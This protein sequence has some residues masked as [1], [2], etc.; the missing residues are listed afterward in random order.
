MRLGTTTQQPNER[1]SY[2]IVYDDALDEGDSVSLVELCIAEPDDMSVSPV[3][4]TDSR[5][6]V[7]CEGGT[8]GETYKVT[9]RVLTAGG[10]KL[11]DELFIRVRGI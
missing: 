11:E 10:E 5:V 1:K 8:T 2:S 3:L 9:V 6:R 4:A 7:W